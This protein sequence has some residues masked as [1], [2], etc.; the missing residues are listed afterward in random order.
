MEDQ[1]KVLVNLDEYKEFVISQ[2][3]NGKLKKTLIEDIKELKQSKNELEGRILI[4][5]EKLKNNKEIVL[6]LTFKRNKMGSDT[7][8][9]QIELSGQWAGFEKEAQKRL[10]ELGYTEKELIDYI[11]EQWDIRECPQEMVSDDES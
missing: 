3:E 7:R 1:S 10:F 6:G 11:N 9:E 5:N 4:L 8:S 2:Y